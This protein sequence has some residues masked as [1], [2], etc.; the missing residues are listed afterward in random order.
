MD[1][2]STCIS[3]ITQLVFS[4]EITEQDVLD[5]I[6]QTNEEIEQ[7]ILPLTTRM[8]A[9]GSEIGNEARR[10]AT[11]RDDLRQELRLLAVDLNTNNLDVSVCLDI[12]LD[13]V[14]KAFGQRG[15]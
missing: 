9:F 1:A 3:L 15:R 8:Q 13:D 4:Q 14:D 2:E 10:L 5:L 11:E 12:A 6:N 7:Y